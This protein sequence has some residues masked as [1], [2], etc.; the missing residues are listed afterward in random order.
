ML[1]LC[2]QQYHYEGMEFKGITMVS[3]KM[4]RN[5]QKTTVAY[6]NPITYGNPA[7]FSLTFLRN[8]KENYTKF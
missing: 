3:I 5:A 2:I 7:D 1:G 4:Y 8:S 6:D